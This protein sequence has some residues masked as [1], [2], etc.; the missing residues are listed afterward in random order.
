M[1][2]FEDTVLNMK[3][4][5]DSVGEKTGKLVDV[6]KLKINECEINNTISK[7][8]ENLGKLF[9]NS[10]KFNIDNEESINESIFSLEV[11]YDQLRIINEQIAK[12]K[13]KKICGNCS[14]IN[15]PE[16]LFCGKCGCK[17]DEDSEDDISYE[18]YQEPESQEEEKEEEKSILKKSE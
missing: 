4:A 10:K 5:F 12:F 8:L 16:M 2:L 18:F 13:K 17:V 15:D 11:F 6:S 7:E 14:S 3:A 9:Y 1:G